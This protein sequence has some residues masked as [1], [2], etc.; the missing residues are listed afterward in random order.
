M[1]PGF[2]LLLTAAFSL[3]VFCLTVLLLICNFAVLLTYKWSL[4]GD[5]F[6][7]PHLHSTSRLDVLGSLQ[8]KETDVSGTHA[9]VMARYRSR[10]AVSQ[11][12]ALMVKLL[13]CTV[14]VLN[15]T[16]MVVRLSWL[17]SFLVK[18]D[19]KLLF[20]TPDSP[21]RTTAKHTKTRSGFSLGFDRY[22]TQQTEQSLLRPLHPVFDG[23]RDTSSQHPHFE[24]FNAWNP[25]T[26]LEMSRSGNWCNVLHY[27]NEKGRTSVRWVQIRW[28]EFDLVLSC[29]VEASC[30]VNRRQTPTFWACHCLV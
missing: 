14:R 16:P 3:E 8:R 26:A 23:R 20:P 15:S 17:N 19:S 21:M 27:R 2:C 12:W 6:S 9:E 11:I 7:A 18:R 29:T 13:S 25:T 28:N 5:V 24:W 4:E 10:P 30:W 1:L 22:K